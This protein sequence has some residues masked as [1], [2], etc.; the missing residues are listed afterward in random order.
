MAIAHMQNQRSDSKA[1]SPLSAFLRKIAKDERGSISILVGGL[2]LITISL[3]IILTSVAEVAVAKRSLTQ[4]TESA[5][6]RGVRNLDKEAYYQGEF[7]EITMVSNLFG[8]GP[9]DP[10]IPIDCSAAKGDV[11]QGLEDW[12]NGDRSL[13]RVELSGVEIKE[14]SCD[15]FGLQVTVQARVTLPLSL[16]FIDLKSVLIESTVGTI[17]SRDKGLYLFGIRI[18]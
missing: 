2:F 12:A 16:P 18:L 7:D 15:G 8:A 3:L 11:L 17:N 4:A 6:Q 9:D 14:I 1:N 10:G 5:A 13:T